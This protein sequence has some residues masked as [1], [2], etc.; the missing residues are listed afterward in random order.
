METVA[1]MEVRAVVEMGTGTRIKTGGRTRTG[2]ARAEKRRRSAND[3]TGAGD[4]MWETR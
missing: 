3:F 1:G 4:A 2:L